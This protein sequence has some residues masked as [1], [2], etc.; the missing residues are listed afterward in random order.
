M[1]IVP[2]PPSV[3]VLFSVGKVLL[4][5]PFGLYCAQVRTMVTKKNC[6]LMYVK[7][8]YPAVHEDTEYWIASCFIQY[9][10]KMSYAVTDGFVIQGVVRCF[11]QFMTVSFSKFDDLSVHCEYIL[12]LPSVLTGFLSTVWFC[13]VVPSDYVEFNDVMGFPSTRWPASWW[14]LAL[15][16][17]NEVLSYIV[18]VFCYLALLHFVL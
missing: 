18:M 10:M 15:L 11:L 1:R 8:G 12:F 2:I 4:T 6:V 13:F 5:R 9:V 17:W 14:Y 7:M 3:G 16:Y